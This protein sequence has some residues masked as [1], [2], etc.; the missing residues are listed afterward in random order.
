VRSVEPSITEG[1]GEGEG[2]APIVHLAPAADLAALFEAIEA[3]RE[4]WRSVRCRRSADL[5]TERLAAERL[6]AERLA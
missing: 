6:A 1:G 5:R 3:E 4:L 2:D